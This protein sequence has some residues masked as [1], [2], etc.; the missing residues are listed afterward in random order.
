MRCWD[1]VLVVLLIFLNFSWNSCFSNFKRFNGRIVMKV[2]KIV[3]DTEYKFESFLAPNAS[4]NKSVTQL[5]ASKSATTYKWY[6]CSF[7]QIGLINHKSCKI[8]LLINL[9]TVFTVRESV[10]YCRIINV[11]YDMSDFHLKLFWKVLRVV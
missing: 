5:L 1:L 7:L 4:F 3:C 2:I 9:H 8:R 6:M 10:Q 11:T